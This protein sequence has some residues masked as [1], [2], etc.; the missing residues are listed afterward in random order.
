MTFWIKK[1][2]NESIM[3]ALI[4]FEKEDYAK[5]LKM[6]ITLESM[7]TKEMIWLDS[8]MIKLSTS[9]SNLQNHAYPY[10]FCNREMTCAHPCQGFTLHCPVFQTIMPINAALTVS[11]TL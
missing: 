8:F 5:K 6:C 2:L 3:D 11:L 7:L 4:Q 9:V 10:S 1:P